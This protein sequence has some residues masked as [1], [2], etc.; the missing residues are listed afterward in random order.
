MSSAA[1]SGLRRNTR[2][3]RWL[4]VCAGIADWLDVPATLVRVVFVI[5]VITWP[6][7]ILGYFILYFCLSNDLDPNKVRDYV[8]GSKLKG[9]FQGVN[10]RKPIYKNERDKRIA[11]VCSGIA[12]YLEISPFTVRALTFG[13]LFVF[14]PFTFWGYII[15]AFVFDPDPL[16][17]DS[18]RY[19]RKMAKRDHRRE[20]RRRFKER[21][22]ERKAR[23]NG[24]SNSYVNEEYMQ[25]RDSE[26]EVYTD[27]RAD[28][29]Q[30]GDSVNLNREECA[31][32]YRQLESRLRGVEAYMT[33][34]QFRLHCEINRI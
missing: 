16:T 3:A 34:K 14:G 28:E 30:S 15:C 5:C 6:T 21:R 13:S 12:D 25:N 29:Q 4:G 19:A 31:K 32:L 18:D 2:N 17:M 23:K 8:N 7:L 9:H 24:F 26:A 11:G 22:A 10:Y 20:K 27:D 1:N 33:S